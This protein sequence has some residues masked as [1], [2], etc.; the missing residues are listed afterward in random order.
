MDVVDGQRHYY[1]HYMGWNKKWD[2]WQTELLEHTPNNQQLAKELKNVAEGA[3][4]NAKRGFEK[5]RKR[6]RPSSAADG[7]VTRDLASIP[8]TFQLKRHLVDDWEVRRAAATAANAAT[9]ARASPVFPRAPDGQGAQARRAAAVQAHG[10]HHSDRVRG[11][12]AHAGHGQGVAGPL[13][14]TTSR[15]LPP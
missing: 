13:P 8:L 3:R 2:E 12:E 9:R 15:C 14:A 4:S 1:V 7:P 11:D 10:A 6:Q 5:R